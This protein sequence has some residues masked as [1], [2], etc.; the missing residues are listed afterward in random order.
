LVSGGTNFG[1]GNRTRPSYCKA[2]ERSLERSERG[3]A[4]VFRL[5]LPLG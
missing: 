1:I 3:T 2:L 5:D 4:Q